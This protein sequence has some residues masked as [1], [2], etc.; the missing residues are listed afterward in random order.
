MTR[1]NI[2]VTCPLSLCR[3]QTL[4]ELSHYPPPHDVKHYVCVKIHWTE[5]K[6]PSSQGSEHVD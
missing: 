6:E 4:L 2:L 5:T 1:L 3:H